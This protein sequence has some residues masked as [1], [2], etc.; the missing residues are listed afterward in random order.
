MAKSALPEEVQK[1]FDEKVFPYYF[2]ILRQ[3]DDKSVVERVLENFRE[4]SIDFG[5]AIFQNKLPEVL[6]FL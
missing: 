1:Y 5:P 6:K 3:E 2:T 4:L